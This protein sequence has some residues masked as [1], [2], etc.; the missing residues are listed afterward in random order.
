M[1]RLRQDSTTKL[2]TP[3]P[4]DPDG[5]CDAD[6]LRV[7]DDL[8][9]GLVVVSKAGIPFTWDKRKG[10]GYSGAWL[11]YTGKD[12]S[13]FET[14]FTIWTSTQEDAWDAWA[15]KYLA[16][17]AQPQQNGVF[18]PSA[19]RPKALGVYNPILAELK[20]TAI[21]P[22]NIGQ[23]VLGTGASKGKQTKTVQW[24]Q[25]RAP[26]PMLGKPNTA[27]PDSKTAP[28]ADDALQLQIRSAQADVAA[29]QKLLARGHQ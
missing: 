17:P 7:G 8:T 12:L 25:F 5:R 3:I 21:V 6:V 11:V 29:R 16:E 26:Q 19:P 27:I 28:S 10:Y 2:L 15:A 14:T 22:G 1:I 9:P 20:I 4:G 13:E 24:F 23:W 18:L